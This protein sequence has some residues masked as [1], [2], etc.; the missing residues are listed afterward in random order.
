MELK[1]FPSTS[2]PVH[3]LILSTTT[4]MYTEAEGWNDETLWSEEF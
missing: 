1:Q 2:Y 4:T 3:L